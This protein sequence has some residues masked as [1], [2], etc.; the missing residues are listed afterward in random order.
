MYSLKITSFNELFVYRN[1]GKDCVIQG[2]LDVRAMVALR[3]GRALYITPIASSLY[4]YRFLEYR[5]FDKICQDVLA[6]LVWFLS[7]N[8]FCQ[9]R[10]LFLYIK[11]SLKYNDIFDIEND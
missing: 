9:R 11:I 7:R 5:L 6:K 1:Q 2:C 10:K 3:Q 8:T 4:C